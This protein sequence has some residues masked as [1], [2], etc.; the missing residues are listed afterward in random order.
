MQVQTTAKSISRPMKQRA[1][2]MRV[3]TMMVMIFLAARLA[4]VIT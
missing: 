4:L 1:Q 2:P 3:N